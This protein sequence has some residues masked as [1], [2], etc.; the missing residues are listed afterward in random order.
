M[1]AGR[2]IL[3]AYAPLCAMML[4]ALVPSL[5]NAARP[6]T[7][8]G[9]LR[10]AAPARP[11]KPATSVYLVQLHQPA[12]ASYTGGVPGLPSTR[13]MRGQRLDR[14]AGSVAS[15]V[16]YLENRHDEILASVGAMNGKLYSLRYALNGFA[17]RLSSAQAASLARHP[18]VERI[19]LDSDQRVQTNNTDIFLGLLDP[20]G[21]LRA[22][23]GL[24]GEGIVIGVIDSGIAVGHPALT[25]STKHIPRACRSQWARS[26]WL[27]RWLCHAVRSN[28]PTTLDY[29]PVEGFSGVCQTGEGFTEE[30]CNNKIVGA[31]Y[32]IDG[33]LARHT[34]DDGEFVSPRDADGHGTHIATTIAGNTV[35][36]SLFGT[37]VAEINGIAP[38][39]RI[40]VYKACWLRD[41]DTRAS[42]TTSDLARAIDD[43]VA[44]GV[45]I[46][47]YSVG[48]L[49]TDL[50]APDDM[51]LLNALNAGVLSVVAAGNDGPN[52]GT[53]GS[54]SSAPWVLTVAASTHTGT[55]FIEALEVTAPADLV[56]SIPMSEASF[57]PSLTERA[58]V[59]AELVL[60]DD[61]ETV[62]SNGR[63]GTTRD[64]CEPLVNSAA[65]SG[66]V[67]LIERGDCEFQV[68]IQHADDAG[69]IATLVY[70]DSGPP[71]VMNGD[72]GSVTIPA[73][74]IG[75]ADGQRLLDRLLT[76]DAEAIEV[77]IEKG[78]FL[79]RNNSGNQMSDFSS[80]GPALSESDFLKP[81]VTA[82]GV[83]IL[84]GHTPDAANGLR[85]QLYQYLSGTSMSTPHVAG[86]AALL[87]EANPDWSASV[88]KSA[89][90]TT[91]YQGLAQFDPEFDADPFDM[92]AGH[93][94]PNL[95]ID[96][97]LVYDTEYLD[98][99]AFLCGLDEPPFLAS[100]C[101]ILA[102]AGLSFEPR[103]LNLPSVGITE[104]VTGDIVTRRVTNLGPPGTYRASV[105]SPF[106]MQV[107]VEP[108][109]LTLG[110][111]ET[112]DFSLIFET[113]SPDLD[114]WTF[115]ELEW[116]DDTRVV[117]SPIAVRPVSLRAPTELNLLGVAGSGT[118]PMA[119]GFDGPYNPSLH[120][121]N[122]P[123]YAAE[124]QLIQD[125][126]TNSFSFRADNGVDQH[127]FTVAP[128]DIYLRISMFDE[129]TDGADD[130][131]L[132]L[133]FC[134]GG[135]CVQVAESGSFTSQEEI[136]LA[137]PPPGEYTLLVH[138][139][140]TDQV[141]GGP[142]AVY[143]L[144]A[145]TIAD[146][147][148]NDS[149][150]ITVPVSVQ[151]GDRVDIGIDW[152]PLDPDVRYFGGIVHGTPFAPN[153][154]FTLLNAYTP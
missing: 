90:M 92:G 103:E 102:L 139:F 29:E 142:G 9:P 110:T 84:A 21:G 62:L 128:G 22:D 97:G 64:A 44:D 26:S 152:G 101:E 35:S 111:G 31:R 85:G 45:D 46:I 127:W 138:A 153:Y 34:L 74:M 136:N 30:Y 96:P 87:L 130:L 129:L 58:A 80:R 43:A 154:S 19:W 5:T 72:S 63:V 115:G 6:S 75:N 134:P 53:I 124:D 76:E 144:H 61:G 150:A 8:S 88:I 83:E 27:G 107:L 49:E 60:A 141:T 1:S 67:V 147:D 135:N 66:H 41:G 120:G 50:T 125:D 81:D 109:T 148:A 95:A 40:A 47:N 4:T 2:P 99:A 105:S 18:D 48:S 33:F 104:L 56:G 118:F 65:A 132:Y 25:D 24:R 10:S 143:S 59:Q 20:S 86:V 94:D 32:Y 28:P 13:P 151:A 89:L 140:E 113:Q 54:P 78:V 108:E 68:K 11:T 23:L 114:L 52:L 122:P 100:D 126:P 57:T 82:P 16:T 146:N 15:Y 3:R 106:G 73:V 36:A 7:P 117:Q 38:R 70:N 77:R 39:A 123:F 121:L 133:Y 137:Y 91:A 98:H 14:N 55:T 69:A 37:R 42:C 71:I 12:A 149:I 131:D 116:S 145:W 79:E 51:A 93:I 112:A 119:F 17:A